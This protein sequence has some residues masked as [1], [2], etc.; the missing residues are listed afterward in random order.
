LYKI[1]NRTLDQVIYVCATAAVHKWRKS[2]IL[3]N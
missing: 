2:Y 1:W 3:D